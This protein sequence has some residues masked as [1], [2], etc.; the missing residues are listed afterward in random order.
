MARCAIQCLSGKTATSST[1]CVQVSLGRSQSQRLLISAFLQETINACPTATSVH[2]EL[3]QL[4]DWLMVTTTFRI[5]SLRSSSASKY[6]A[7]VT[8]YLARCFWIAS[9]LTP[10]LDSVVV[11]YNLSAGDCVLRMKCFLCATQLKELS[12]WSSR[13]ESA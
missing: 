8:V 7:V 3:L 11:H 2:W 6:G 9:K 1:G 5:T 4:K 12:S 13:H 10:Y